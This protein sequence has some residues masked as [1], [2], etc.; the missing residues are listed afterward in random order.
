MPINWHLFQATATLI[1]PRVAGE[2]TWA[3]QAE[4]TQEQFEKVYRCLEG[5]AQKIEAEEGDSPTQ[6]S[7]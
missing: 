2:V 1:A 4:V 5:I 7:S 3:R 6:S